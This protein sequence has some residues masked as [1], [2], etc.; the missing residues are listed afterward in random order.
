MLMRQILILPFLLL[1][2][3]G[4]L[5]QETR[6]AAIV[7]DDVVS[8]D[9]LS[10][11]MRLVMRSSGIEDTPE[12]RQRISGQVLRSLID[13][14]LEMQEVKRLNVSVSK[15]EVDQA[16]HRIEQNNNMPKGAL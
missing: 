2:A 15:D 5:A 6:I 13:E 7:N 11:R 3:G 14:K 12:N 1:L 16:F 8:L 10:N 4:A 9:D